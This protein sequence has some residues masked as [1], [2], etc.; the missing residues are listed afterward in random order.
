VIAYSGNTGLSTGPHLHFAMRRGGRFI[1]PLNQ[2]FPRAAPLPK[3]LWDDFGRRISS[4]VA[5]L[6]VQS[7]AEASRAATVQ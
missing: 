4:W 3:E 2:R 6:E 5:S 1:N 7:V